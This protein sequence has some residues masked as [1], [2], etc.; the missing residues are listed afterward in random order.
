MFGAKAC[1]TVR[2][3]TTTDLG[4]LADEL[5]DLAKAIDLST[6]ERARALLAQASADF[7]RAE[8]ADM[9]RMSVTRSSELAREGY[10]QRERSV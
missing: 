5:V 6:D 9:A 7:Q 4:A 3:A 10:L 1:E 2:G 8:R